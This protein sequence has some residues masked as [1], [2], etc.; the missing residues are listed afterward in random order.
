MP[1]LLRSSGDRIGYPGEWSFEFLSV[2]TATVIFVPFCGLPQRFQRVD[3]RG[4][5][6]WN[7][8]RNKDNNCQRDCYRDERD[9]VY[10]FDSKQQ[11][12]E[13]TSHRNSANSSNT[14][15]HN[16][17]QHR[18]LEHEFEHVDNLRPQRHSHSNLMRSLRHVIRT[19]AV[20]AE[21]R[22]K[23]RDTRKSAQQQHRSASRRSRSRDHV[24]H[25][26]HVVCRCAFVDGSNRFA[27]R[28][29]ER[30]WFACRAH[31]QREA[32]PRRILCVR[33]VHLVCWIFVERLLGI[34]YDT[35]NLTRKLFV[36]PHTEATADR[37][38]VG[39]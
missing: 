23:Q 2:N 27:H 7:Q 34:T 5:A 35:D 21:H 26:S 14:N 38:L 12:R 39:P 25:R 17:Q 28:R 31:N 24:V 20:D 3:L 18:A 10:W 30:T 22:E 8:T 36:A 9:D 16:R 19:D 1:A 13:I 32:A 4:P 6:S 33:N 37:I 29:R 15:P 11:R